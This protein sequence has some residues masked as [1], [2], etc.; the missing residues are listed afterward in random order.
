MRVDRRGLIAAYNHGL[1]ASR[2]AIVAFV[3][4]DAVPSAN[5]LEAVVRTFGRDGQIAAVGGRDMIVADGRVIEADRRRIL[6]GAHEV[7]RIQWFG[8]MIG[9]HHVGVGEARDVDVLKGVNMSFRRAAVMGHGFDE[10]LQGRGVE[11]HSELSICLPLR[12]KGLRV[13]YDPRIVVRHYPAPRRYGY[14]RDELGGEAMR[15]AVH[16][17]ALAILDYFGALRRLI[18]MAWGF[19]CGATHGPGL[20]ILA[21]DLVEGRPAAWSRFSAAQRGRLAAWR[22][23]R[24][25]RS[26]PLALRHV[27]ERPTA[28]PAVSCGREPPEPAASVVV[29]TYRRMDRLAACLAGL[30]SQARPPD[31]VVVVVH[32]SDEE[33]ARL[34][35]GSAS[36]WPALRCVRRRPARFCGGVQPRSWSIARDDRRVCR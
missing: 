29:A 17:E 27:A 36:D 23:R 10:R 33:S 28:G 12:R 1:G 13:V 9:N 3:D 24:T 11:I 30:R 8:R 35:E 18:F 16:N 15:A 32:S 4:D 7:G 14:G 21:R 5:W 25:E 2:G 20:I 6:T 31:E 34:V 19:V 26:V 22:S